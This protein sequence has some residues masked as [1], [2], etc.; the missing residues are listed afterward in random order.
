MAATLNWQLEN[1]PAQ[2]GV[3]QALQLSHSG[4]LLVES[5]PLLFM[6]SCASATGCKED[7]A[8]SSSGMVEETSG[9]GWDRGVGGQGGGLEGDSWQ[10]GEI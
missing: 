3:Q 9:G 10:A 8:S 4:Q 6:Q 7:H 5:F 1:K 2:G